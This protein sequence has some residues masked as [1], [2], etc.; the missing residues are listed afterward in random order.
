MTIMHK[1]IAE[2]AIESGMN[3][4]NVPYHLDDYI[5]LGDYPEVEKFARL[6]VRECEYLVYDSNI[7]PIIYSKHD[8]IDAIKKH[9]GV[10]DE[11]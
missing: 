4:D 11:Y 10:D 5:R 1:R 7:E 9:F 8:L 2:L 6:I 3:S